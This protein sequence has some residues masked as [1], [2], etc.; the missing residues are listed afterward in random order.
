MP[1]LS[2]SQQ[3]APHATNTPGARSSRKQNRRERSEITGSQARKCAW[4]NTEASAPEI[5][6][7]SPEDGYRQ[8][9]AHTQPPSAPRRC[10]P[11]LPQEENRQ[12]R[13][14][15]QP[16]LRH[17]TVA[18]RKPRMP[19]FEYRR[20]KTEKRQ[21]CARPHARRSR[22]PCRNAGRRRPPATRQRRSSPER[23]QST[24]CAA[25]RRYHV[26]AKN[27]GRCPRK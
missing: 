16:S 24:A 7:T 10:P 3:H 4:S 18:E 22:P 8:R 21:R 26:E 14:Y 5:F 23:P 1:S 15:V 27:A 19:P 12:E 6:I 11:I 13:G 20:E 17:G 25:A 2:D 9:A